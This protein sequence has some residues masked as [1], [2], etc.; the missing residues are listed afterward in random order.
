MIIFNALFIIVIG[1]IL[2]SFLNVVIYR[3]PIMMEK[4]KSFM[5][6]FNLFVP[7]SHCR[8]C[9]KTIKIYQNIP[10]FSYLFL[11]GKCV[12][13]DHTISMQYPF[14]EL[15]TSICTVHAFLFFNFS[16]E[17]FAILIFIYALIVISVIDFNHKIIPDSLSLILLTSGLIYSFI[18][19][20]HGGTSFFIEP[21][22][23][24]SGIFMGYCL[25]FAIYKIHFSLTGKEGLGFGDIKLLA[26]LGTWIG[27]KLTPLVL[28][29][30]AIFGLIYALSITLIKKINIDESIPFGP[31]LALSGWITLFYNAKILE[32]V[33]FF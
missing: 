9:K 5:N 32:I 25:L 8:N 2:G 22:D 28:F 15:L 20:S 11:K 30:A 13:C 26:A 24:I 12:N 31:F 10:V 23:S 3:L 18:F 16:P 17:L 27:W 4:K 33:T 14:I 1:L 6:D 21:V 7:R 19:S 29:L